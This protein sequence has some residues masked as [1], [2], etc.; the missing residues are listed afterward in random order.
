MCLTIWLDK[1]NEY[2]KITYLTAQATGNDIDI[3]TL[4]IEMI[5]NAPISFD[6]ITNEIYKL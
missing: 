3:W 1:P 2:T 4:Y 6:I 5:P